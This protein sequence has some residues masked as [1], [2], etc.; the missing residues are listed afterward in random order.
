MRAKLAGEQLQEIAL[1]GAISAGLST[2]IVLALPRGGDLAAQLYRTDLVR[3]GYLIWDNLWFAG[4][5]PLASYSLLYYALAVVGNPILGVVG[6][7]VTAGLFASVAQREWAGLGRWPARSFGV[8]LTGQVFT[9]AYPYDVGI[10]S[11]LL[12][13]WA[14]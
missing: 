11:L 4:Q 12:S 7:V 3:H 10:A 14:L 8:L 6:V 13:V 2:L 1:C 5:Y 9:G